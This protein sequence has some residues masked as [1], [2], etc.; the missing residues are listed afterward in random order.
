[1]TAETEQYDDDEHDQLARARLVRRMRSE[2]GTVAYET[3]LAACRDEKAPWNA[4][5]QAARSILDAGGFFKTTAHD[6]LEEKN[7]AEMTAAELDQAVA[8][9]KASLQAPKK[10][11]ASTPPRNTLKSGNAFD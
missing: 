5:T 10:R 7:P 1:M 2:G 6:E 8:R 3:C 11:S 4:R 9:A